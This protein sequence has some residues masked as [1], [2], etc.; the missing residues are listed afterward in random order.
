MTDGTPREPEELEADARVLSMPARPPEGVLAI[1][2]SRQH[3]AVPDG[4]DHQGGARPGTLSPL[5]AEVARVLA[6][7]SRR[8]GAP[9]PTGGTR[10]A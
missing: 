3:D 4:S 10:A 9:P 8:R 7:A 6:A 1:R 2:R 5:W